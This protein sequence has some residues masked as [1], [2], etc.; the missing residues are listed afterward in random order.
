MDNDIKNDHTQMLIELI[1]GQAVMKS[2]LETHIPNILGRIEKQEKDHKE[3]EARHN[4]LYGSHNVM[5]WSIYGGSA[6]IFFLFSTGVG[7]RIISVLST[8]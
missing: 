3:L 2:Q 6:A 5:R 8:Q 4:A 7:Q 1:S